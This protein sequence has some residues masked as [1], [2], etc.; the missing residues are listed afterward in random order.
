MP[1]DHPAPAHI[2][3]HDLPKTGV[4]R[5]GAGAR[6]L[7]RPQCERRGGRRL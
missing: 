1:Q 2:A 4:R 5:R 3:G 6:D 7:A